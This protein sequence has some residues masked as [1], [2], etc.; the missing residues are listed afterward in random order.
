MKIVIATLLFL[1]ALSAAG[2]DPVLVGAGD[3]ADCKTLSGA[4]KTAALLDQI[5][6]TVFTLGD[7]AY[8]SGTPREFAD[9]YGP[10]WGRHKA[11]TRPVV[12][13]HDYRTAFA[14]GYFDYFGEA[15]G[16][17]TKGYYS[18]DLGAWH[19]VVINSNCTQVGGCKDGSPQV[20]WLKKD[21]AEHPA[22]CTAAMWHHPRFSS[23]RE[24]G[25]DAGMKGVWQVLAAAGAEL[26]VSGHD[27]DYERFA[28]LDAAGKPDPHGVRQFVVGTGGRE[29]YPWGSTRPGS[30]VRNNET[31]GVL[32]LTLHADGYDWEF[33]PVE[34]ESFHDKGS[35]VCR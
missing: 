15:A 24:H 23:G 3:I 25:D 34:G 20:E 9:C 27:H 5:P 30:E 7:N 4:A 11:R 32:K 14:N 29:L 22:L 35:D 28:R 33:I 6:G 13:N 10:T 26:V 19:I 12:G 21:L 17:R 2:Q 8:D 18:Y 31:F 16:D 1:G